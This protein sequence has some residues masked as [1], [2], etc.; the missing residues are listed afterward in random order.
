MDFE[1]GKAEHAL[2][3]GLRT[4]DV[5]DVVERELAITSDESEIGKE[6]AAAGPQPPLER[7]HDFEKLT[8]GT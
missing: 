3:E 8:L 4:I 5:A 6:I 7:V 1:R 2:P